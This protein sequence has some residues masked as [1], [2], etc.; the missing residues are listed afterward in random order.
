MVRF[1]ARFGLLCLVRAGAL[2]GGAY[3][4]A[5]MPLAGF[6]HSMVSQKGM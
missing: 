1:R 6:F 2:S 5:S 3:A 4:A